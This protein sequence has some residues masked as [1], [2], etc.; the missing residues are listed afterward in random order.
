MTA[1]K[2]YLDILSYCSFVSIVLILQI[3]MLALLP[4]NLLTIECFPVQLFNYKL[5]YLWAFFSFVFV[6]PTN[7]N[8]TSLNAENF[9]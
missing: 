5:D 8:S 3:A 6:F 9:F 1:L 2:V 4:W 7:K